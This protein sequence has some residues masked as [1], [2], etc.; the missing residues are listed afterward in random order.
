MPPL[1]R[2]LR[3]LET[4]GFLRR[5]QL[6]S[7]DS[8]PSPRVDSTSPKVGPSISLSLPLLNAATHLITGTQCEYRHL[9]T[10]KVPSQCPLI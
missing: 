3:S 10:G 2:S 7:I 9:F 8:Y 6:N 5:R 1:R 4:Y